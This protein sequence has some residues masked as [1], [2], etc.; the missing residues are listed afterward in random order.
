[1]QSG[2]RRVSQSRRYAQN[3]RGAEYPIRRV[4][5]PLLK[6]FG[7]DGWTVQDEV[8]LSQSPEVDHIA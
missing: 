5:R 2:S 6:E 4:R 3:D 7:D 8:V 1:M